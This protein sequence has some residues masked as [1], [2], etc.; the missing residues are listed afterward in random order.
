MNNIKPEIQAL[1]LIQQFILEQSL[2]A[3]QQKVLRKTPLVSDFSMVMEIETSLS[4]SRCWF[5]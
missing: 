3:S 4:L 2:V 1:L 5:R